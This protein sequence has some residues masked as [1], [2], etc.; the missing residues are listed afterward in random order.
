MI[1]MALYINTFGRV[2]NQ[3][4]WNNLPKVLKDNTRIVVQAREYPQ[5][6][7]FEKEAPPNQLIVLP[8]SIRTLSPTRQYTLEC[9]AKYGVNKMVILD[10]DLRFYYRPDKSKLPMKPS[11]DKQII[12]MFKELESFLD[13]G[14]IHAGV[15]A[16]ETNRFCPHQYKDCGALFRLLAYRPKEVLATGARFDRLTIMQGVDM[17]LQLISKGYNNRITFNYAHAHGKPQEAGGVS[18]YRTADVIKKSM[19]EFVKL[20][21]PYIIG[22]SKP[23]KNLGRMTEEEKKAFVRY[24]IGWQRALKIGLHNPMIDP[25]L[26]P[27]K[28]AKVV[29][30]KRKAK[31]RV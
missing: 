24:K 22:K 9:A 28:P 2:D 18:T 8:D 12:A 13:A 30:R 6:K 23:R 20:N 15:S 25:G 3:V 16:K 1:G 17:S 19:E 5:W 31:A 4:T 14:F 11:E 29:R 27:D 7:S 26:P 10:D 21:H